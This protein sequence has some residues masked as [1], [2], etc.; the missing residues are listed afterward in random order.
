MDVLYLYDF[1]ESRFCDMEGA[2]RYL[3]VSLVLSFRFV[4]LVVCLSSSS[5]I[6]LLLYGGIFSTT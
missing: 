5:F 4:V 1:Y 2:D 3:L 6:L